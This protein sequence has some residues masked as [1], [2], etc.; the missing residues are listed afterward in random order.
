MMINDTRHKQ[1]IIIK[2][3]KLTS[4]RESLVG[5]PCYPSVSFFFFLIVSMVPRQSTF[6]PMWTA[7]GQIPA[8]ASA[9][10]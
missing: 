4:N 9:V 5:K 3:K 8:P 10:Q 1:I 2:K 6:F 7:I